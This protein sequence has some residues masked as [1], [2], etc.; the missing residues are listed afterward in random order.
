MW[1]SAILCILVV[2]LTFYQ[3]FTQGLFSSFIMAGLCMIS[4]LLALNFYEPLAEILG[5]FGI[6]SFGPQTICLMGLFFLSLLALRELTDRL[7]RGNMNF[8]LFIDRIGAA[9]F[10][11]ISSMIVAGMIALGFQH[12]SIP[13][14]I[15]GF[16]RCPNLD[17]T[18][19]DKGLFPGA[20]GFVVSLVSQASRFSFAGENKFFQHHPDF[21]R[22]LYLNRL[23]LDPASRIDAC[24]EAIGNTKKAWLIDHDLRD[25]LSMQVVRAPEGQ[26]FVAVRMV[27]KT[28]AV[29]A[30]Q[31]GA[32]DVD[33]KVRFTL[34][35]VRLVGFDERQGYSRY[36]IGVLMPGGRMIEKIPLNQG[37]I[38]TARNRSQ[39][40]L[41]FEWPMDL[42]P[43]PRYLE[44]KRSAR[45]SMPDAG[46]LGAFKLDPQDFYEAAITATEADI[47]ALTEES[48][49]YV[50]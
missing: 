26:R 34:G 35:S 4:A 49:P 3:V 14:E 18:Q 10:G 33:G 46:R 40:D 25:I 48:T 44:F 20:D 38:L 32:V 9:V 17:N 13:A 1:A 15:L 27:V 6:G 5:R 28:S 29:T 23:A 39:V 22:E 42:E 36:P 12:L 2:V 16:N 50:L 30:K 7:I 45:V 19:E 11:L 24:A 31:S 21:L 8:P 47:K 37:K 41:V 43:S